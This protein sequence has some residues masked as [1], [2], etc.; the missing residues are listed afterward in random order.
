MGSRNVEV[1]SVE[2]TPCSSDQC[3]IFR[4]EPASINITFKAEKDI[5][6]GDAVVQGIYNNHTIPL[7]FP[8]KTVCSHL[9]PHCPIKEGK[10]YTF[11]H[12]HVVSQDFQLVNLEVRWELLDSSK[13][14]FVCVQFPVQ[15]KQTTINP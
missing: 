14:P 15:I 1:L 3:V 8:D 2:V 5:A 6:A 4:G 12:T 13:I 9:T 11:G 7:P 10:M